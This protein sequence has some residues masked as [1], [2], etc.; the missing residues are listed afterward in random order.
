MYIYSDMGVQQQTMSGRWYFRRLVPLVAFITSFA[1]LIGGASWLWGHLV[2]IDGV[3]ASIIFLLIVLISGLLWLL[4]TQIARL[5]QSRENL[6]LTL[7]SSTDIVVLLDAQAQYVEIFATTD[8]QLI[9]SR[10]KVL[11]K[12]ISEV[13]GPELGARVESAVAK[14]IRSGEKQIVAYSLPIAGQTFWF[15]AVLSKRDA[16]TVVAMIRDMTVQKNL[17]LQF[18]E[19]RRFMAMILNSISDPIFLKDEQ[20]R[21][22][23]GND[24]FSAILGKQRSEYYGKRDSDFYP[25]EISEAFFKSDVDTFRGMKE[26][27]REETILNSDGPSGDKAISGEAR[28]ILTKKTPFVGADGTKTLIGI[29]RDITDRKILERQLEDERAR[30]VAA[31]RL[32]SLGEMAGGVAHEINNPLAIIS[33]Y[34]GRLADVLSEEVISRDRALEI[35]KRIDKTALRIAAI[36]KGLRAISRD[37]GF[38]AKEETSVDSII[39]DTLGLCAARFKSEGVAVETRIQSDLVLYCRSVQI[40]QV[41]L[42][43]LTNAFFAASKSPDAKITIEA[44]RN[45]DFIE[46]AV[47][48]SGSGIESKIRERIFE[49]FFTTKPVGIGTGLGLPI[50]SSIVREHGGELLLD[51]TSVLTRFVIRMPSSSSA[52]VALG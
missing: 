38:D 9:A 49:P 16:N 6:R 15:E 30:Q 10:D 50:A 1:I 27:E 4:L 25:P 8:E 48:D 44:S 22:L 37:G 24:A 47:Q 7:E 51:S 13:L 43:L 11:G 31:S 17:S 21:W 2:I 3:G 29:I 36:V 52:S 18:E 23:Y 35:V 28:T 14:V 20:H 41:L 32:A 46:I 34:A 39:E 19:Q 45:G 42:N 40:S 26:V 5:H 12:S 33:G